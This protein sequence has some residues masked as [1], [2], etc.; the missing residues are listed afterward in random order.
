MPVPIRKWIYTHVLGGGKYDK[1]LPKPVSRFEKELYDLAQNGVGGGDDPFVIKHITGKMYNMAHLFNGCEELTKIDMSNWDTSNAA[2]MDSMFKDCKNLSSV[3]F[4]EN[5][6]SAAANMSSMFVRCNLSELDMSNWNTSKT[7]T[8]SGMFYE[9]AD[10]V[11]VDTSGWD[12]SKLTEVGLMFKDCV[13]LLYFDMGHWDTSKLTGVDFMFVHCKALEEITG[14]SATGGA[15]LTRAFPYPTS[16]SERPFALR[17]LTFKDCGDT[18]AIRSGFNI[19]YCNFEVGEAGQPGGLREMLDTITDVSALVADG[20]L[21]AAQTKI[22]ITGN[23]CVTGKIVVG[24]HVDEVTENV[25]PD[26][27]MLLTFFDD[28]GLT[29]ATVTYTN[30][31]REQ[32]TVDVTHDDLAMDPLACF[33]DLDPSAGDFI[34]NYVGTVFEYEDCAVID[35]AMRSEFT[36]LGWT[37]VE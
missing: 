21:T 32:V 25:Y 23:P 2:S 3:I 34:V 29:S 35:D 30:M 24:S 8:V 1:D 33:P 9:C 13:N 37:L 36:G 20:T 14:F 4:P 6:G 12:T 18:P 31:S 16:V 28:K 22:T 15:D 19:S 27:Y 11:S 26:P 17:R 7:T 10:L 5:F